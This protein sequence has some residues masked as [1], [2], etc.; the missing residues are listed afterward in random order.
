[1]LVNY[2]TLVMA[3]K[4]V[5]QMRPATTWVSMRTIT[6]VNRD[7]PVIHNFFMETSD[8]PLPIILVHKTANSKTAVL[9]QQNYVAQSGDLLQPPKR[10]VLEQL[11]MLVRFH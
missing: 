1:M 4:T 10:I 8:E 9:L 7:R 6:A 5:M 3:G 2:F 11:E